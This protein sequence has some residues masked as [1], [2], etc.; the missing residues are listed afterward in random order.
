MNKIVSFLLRILPGELPNFFSKPRENFVFLFKRFFLRAKLKKFSS[1]KSLTL[2]LFSILYPTF[3]QT[4]FFVFFIAFFL[5][6][7]NISYFFRQ[8]INYSNFFISTQNSCDIVRVQNRQSMAETLSSEF[9]PIHNPEF[10]PPDASANFK[11]KQRTSA[12]FP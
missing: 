4:V 1:K 3:F 6:S 2:S 8:K 5:L 12:S 9:M 10:L 11:K 7:K